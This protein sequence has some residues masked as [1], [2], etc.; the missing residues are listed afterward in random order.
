MSTAGWLAWSTHGSRR[1]RLRPGA[2]R[3]GSAVGSTRSTP[4]CGEGDL[5]S[6]TPRCWPGR[7]TTRGWPIRCRPATTE[8]VSL[9]RR[10]PFDVWRRTVDELVRLWDQ[11]GAF[12]PDR[13]LARNRLHVR[14]VGDVTVLRGELVGE[15]AVVVR[16]A[17]ESHGRPAVASGP[18]RS[19]RG[20]RA[21]G[22]DPAHA[23]GAGPGRAVP[24]GA[25]RRRQPASAPVVDVTLVYP[26]RRATTCSHPRR[27]TA[28]AGRAWATCCATP[29]RHLLV[30]DDAGL[31]LDLGRTV[32]LRHPGSAAGAGRP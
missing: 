8:L 20:S 15:A 28:R 19:R 24:P 4:R 31:P 5:G 9:A 13:D 27:R 22:P 32:R 26:S 11:D 23:A 12:D 10:L 18:G 25:G 21:A 14:Q 29:A 17:L 30:V 2:C 6:S 1:A 3:R 16:Q 7:C